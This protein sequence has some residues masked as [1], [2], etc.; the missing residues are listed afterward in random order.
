MAIRS[1]SISVDLNRSGVPSGRIVV[2]EHDAGMTINIAI[3]DGYMP[4]NL[5]S[6]LTAQ[7][8]ADAPGGYVE[9]AI[10]L[11]GSTA[12]YTLSSAMTSKHGVCYPY[13]ALLQGEAVVC[14]TE[15]FEL[16]IEKAADLTNGEAQAIQREF[17]RLIGEWEEQI[18]QQD[19]TFNQSEATR[20]EQEQE[21]VEAEEGRVNAESDRVEAEN[22]RVSAEDSR[23]S[24]ESSRASTE[25]VRDSAED[26]RVEAEKSRASAES[27]RVLAENA[28]VSAEQQRETEQNAN[29]DAQ[30]SNDEA[31]EQNN[32]DQEANNQDAQDFADAEHLRVTAENARVTAENLRVDAE[33]DRVSAES[34]R[35]SAETARSNAEATRVSQE[36][37]RVS[38]ESS[39]VVAE[40]DRVEAE[41]QRAQAES[42]RVTA[43]NA[44]ASAESTR[45]SDQAKNNADQALNNQKV[46]ELAPYICTTGEY[47]PDTL[48][49]TIEG[50]PNR[51]YFVPNS[52]GPG[53][54][55]V[56][57]MV[58]NNAW[59]MM[60]VSQV[61]ITSITTDD[62]DSVIDDESPQGESIL[63]LTGLSY[64]WTKLKT[65][66]AAALHNHSASEITSGTMA[67]ARLPII[68]L[69]KGGTGATTAAQALINLGL[70]A[71]ATEI[72]Y[73]DGVSSNIQTQLNNKAASDHTHNYA[74]SNSAGGAANSAVALQT[75]RTFRTNLASTSAASF[76]GTANVTPGVTGT[77]P[78]TNGGTGSSNASGARSNLGI[79]V[80]NKATACS[81]V[82][83]IGDY[84]FNSTGVNPGETKG[85]TWVQDPSM[86]PFAWR[87]T[88]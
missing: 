33:D 29:N 41:Q 39:R 72:N 25:S 31:Q 5:P 15:S 70:Q 21:R 3:V 56:E 7:L 4:A 50:V 26:D 57:W 78:I 24:A 71:T 38:T 11:S 85:G 60:G 47:D 68:A 32:A 64:L 19:D 1:E 22:S 62:I 40:T 30:D 45:A 46:A 66:F 86:G 9:D 2:T 37:S 44:R 49:P 10:S 65:A 14:S 27:E 42:A 79:S 6:G 75:A 43:E 35:A 8:R 34:A 83:E 84:V 12:V 81:N 82:Y 67:A 48:M 17:D 80:Y 23:V 52:Q 28:R 36:Q 88:A 53:N 59:E 13:I 16:K 69:N 55:Y 74:G 18:S 58:I 63:N 76:D 87:R 61:S 73:C 51:I 77:L 54:V 20:D